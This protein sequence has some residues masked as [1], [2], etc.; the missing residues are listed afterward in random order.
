MLTIKV[1]VV[2]D[3]LFMRKLISRLI[4]EDAALQ[5]VG[6]ARNGVEAV[7]LVKKLRPDVV[8]LDIEMPEMDGLEA[9]DKIMTARPTPVLML[10]SLT[11]EGA[12]ATIQA[13]QAGAVDFISK[14]SGSIST[15]LYKVKDELVAKIKLAAQIPARTLTLPGMNMN[16]GMKVRHREKK[17]GIPLPPV[18]KFDQIIALGTSTG[19]P[20][21]LEAVL[22]AL[23]ADFPY[24]LLLV[25]H[26]PPKFT[27]SLAAR[28]DSISAIR[29]VEAQDKEL[30]TGG[31]AYIAPGNYH[32]TAVLKNREFRIELHQLPPRNGH[33]PSADVLFNSVSGLSG[34]KKHFV[35]MTG[36][37][38][39]GAQGMLSAKQAGAH[40]T[41]AEA[42]ETC[43]VF[44]MPR[45][46]IELNCVDYTVP[47]H[48]I[49]SKLEEV[50]GCSKR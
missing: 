7:E 25:Q 45:S 4:D 30:I 17:T 27:A 32:M 15:D 13:L 2:D 36:M 42:K 12:H 18:K 40:S 47:L 19:G 34:L 6:T 21:A 3:S 39:D 23:P 37:G 16:A 48:R 9:L 46:A 29:V 1:L 33:R 43:I 20:K 26:M 22:T 35:L 8:T 49:A 31:T 5:V 28:L 11:Q 41:I 10:S 38:S 14:P 24:P 50:T 44:G